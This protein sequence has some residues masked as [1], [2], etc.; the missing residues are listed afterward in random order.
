MSIKNIYH[1]IKDGITN[2]IYWFPVIWKQRDWD[3]SYIYELLLHKLKRIQKRPWEKY[4]EGGNVS[5]R[6][7]NISIKLLEE[8]IEDNESRYIPKECV[9]EMKFE[10]IPK[11]EKFGR[12]TFLWPFPE[13]EE[14]YKKALIKGVKR[15]EK[16]RKLLFSILEKRIGYW[17]D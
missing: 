4:I 7:V 15:L 17:W 8:L 9:G 14:I 6:Y 3:G 11:G 5:K 10:D 16:A 12:I 1:N 2:L 13:A